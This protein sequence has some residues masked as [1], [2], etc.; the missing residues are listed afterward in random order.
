MEHLLTELRL[1]DAA[2]VKSNSANSMP[3][4]VQRA[5]SE[6]HPVIARDIFIR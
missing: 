1:A 4:R 6:L 5:A 3:Q 2:S